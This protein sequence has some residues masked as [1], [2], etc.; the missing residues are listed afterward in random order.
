MCAEIRSIEASKAHGHG[1]KMREVSLRCL[2]TH[3]NWNKRDWV[4]EREVRSEQGEDQKKEKT[5]LESSH[6]YS[7]ELTELEKT[8]LLGDMKT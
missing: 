3:L 4:N 6:M 8:A 5:H 2:R 7:I 1:L